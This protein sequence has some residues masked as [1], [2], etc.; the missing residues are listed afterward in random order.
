MSALNKF[1]LHLGPE[2]QIEPYTLALAIMPHHFL[3]QIAG[4]TSLE[5]KINLNAPDELSFSTYKYLNGEVNPIWDQIEDLMLVYVQEIDEYFQI[6]VTKIEENSLVKNV[7]G[8]GAAECELA[9]SMI[10]D[11]EINSEVDIIRED[12]LA[13]TQ[14]Y[15]NIKPEN[16]LLHRT[17]Y[18]VPQWSIGHVD[19]S[20]RN[21]QRTFTNVNDS[22]YDFLTGS[23]ADSFGCL[24]E[25]D[26]ANRQIAAYDLKATCLNCGYRNYYTKICPECGSAMVMEYGED[27]HVY[28]DVENLATSIQYDTDIDS[29]KNCFHLEAGDPTLT[30]YVTEINPSG[31]E[32]I[33]Y[34]S[35]DM[36]RQMPPE[37]VE[38]IEE[39]DAKCREIQPAYQKNIEDIYECIDKITYLTHTMMPSIERK[40]FNAETEAAK[41]TSASLSP[42]GVDISKYYDSIAKSRVENAIK[43]YCK[44]YVN[45]ALYK[46]TVNTEYY[47]FPTWRGT[48]TLES[49]ATYNATDP[50]LS[51]KGLRLNKMGKD[52]ATTNTITITVQDDYSRQV[53]Q[54]LTAELQARSNKDEY[55]DVFQVVNARDIPTFKSYLKLYCLKRLESFRD[56]ALQME[57]IC[58]ELDQ[59]RL[60]AEM[61]DLYTN[62]RQKVDACDE[63]IAIRKAEIQEWEDRKAELYQ[64]RNEMQDQMNFRKFLGEEL[65]LVFCMYKREENYQDSN[66]IS[67]KLSD[68]E[69]F[70]M[71]Q[72]FLEKAQERIIE[73]G[74]AQHTIS[75]RL[76][77]FLAMPEF[78]PFK[79]YIKLGNWVNMRIDSDVYRLRL[80][81]MELDFERP[82]N[83]SVEFS[84]VRKIRDGWSDTRDIL[85]QAK[86]MASA[87]GSTAGKA[88]AAKDRADYLD[89][90]V[91]R[92]LD[93]TLVEIVNRA[94]N[95]E[96]TIDEHGLW[97]RRWDILS[98]RY[99]DEQTRIIN[100][101]LYYTMDNWQS[102]SC[103]LGHIYF[104][105][106]RN[107]FEYTHVYGLMAE[108]VIGRVVLS[109]EV[110]IWT[111]NGSI[112]MNE[113]GYH[114]K[115]TR[116][117][118][119]DQ[120]FFEIQY[121]YCDGTPPIDV[122]KIDPTHFWINMPRGTF[123]VVA[124][125]VNLEGSDINMSASNNLNMRGSRINM[126]ATTISMAGTDITISASSH[127]GLYGNSVVDIDGDTVNITGHTAVNINTAS[128][129]IEAT[130]MMFDAKCELHMHGG[131][132]CIKAGKFEVHGD[133]EILLE[134][135]GEINMTADSKFHMEAGEFD[136]L[137][138][139]N[140]N[141]E[142]HVQL[143][144][145]IFITNP[146][147]N[148]LMSIDEKG[149]RIGTKDHY[150]D[151]ESFGIWAS[152]NGDMTISRS[153]AVG[154][155]G[156]GYV[157]FYAE[158]TIES[159][160][161][162]QIL[163]GGNLY[164]DGT[165]SGPTIDALMGAASA[166]TASVT[167][168]GPSAISMLAA[169]AKPVVYDV[170]CALSAQ[171]IMLDEGNDTIGEDG[172]CT[173]PFDETYVM[174]NA[175]MPRVY[176][177]AIGK[178]SVWL[179]E[180][181]DTSFSVEGEA[182]TEFTWLVSMNRKPQEERFPVKEETITPSATA[183]LPKRLPV[184]D[185]VKSI[186]AKSLMTNQE[187]SEK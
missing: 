74:E 105:D 6:Q 95:Q 114:Q 28:F 118:Y 139:S 69:R 63:E 135:K 39:F 143:D 42:L 56:A 108:Y 145:D 43:S 9:Q 126:D 89:D 29:I 138:N 117:D 123:Q 24:F 18:E 27:T 41:L 131:L 93:A 179:T 136:I 130:N 7:V 38:K 116:W 125:T 149:F 99:H 62:Y 45:T 132:V 23:V 36:K 96:M 166:G 175:G 60:K 171:S 48:I 35:D 187:S 161:N 21:M 80:M 162:L 137:S 53:D 133:S 97:L 115:V 177:Q 176:V 113:F 19:T 75:G 22:V 186:V 32:Y 182:G 174:L 10:Y 33:W 91:G 55:G 122:I 119:G 65:W 44:V 59:A 153:F 141:M 86:K 134:C 13:P 158:Q 78:E 84:N 76:I 142:G 14:F 152:S 146:T 124:G 92:G 160:H 17:L 31:T 26:S 79:D 172:T 154:K 83:I 170:P 181:G 98:E 81:S 87:F 157:T 180:I 8:T 120:T 77:D 30:A 104:P 12:Y 5:I 46:V 109:E 70:A 94:D 164:V 49:Y 2:G 66:Y 165:I 148:L 178:E 90:W 50:T 1:R 67:D 57:E 106:P 103:G 52:N 82:E 102:I 100:N 159:G 11:M 15:D 54:R 121:D 4:V 88:D 163:D 129:N 111:K 151:D 101:G 112:M 64:I 3:G 156:V 183:S 58:E 168:S 169:R 184:P 128:F 51:A 140:I 68:P 73:S 127:L 185:E 167:A 72:G 40:E 25:F 147:S 16:S 20:L 110:G 37:L 61:F 144:G 71:A 155:N 47:V 107:N 85:A 150:D 34:F 173:I